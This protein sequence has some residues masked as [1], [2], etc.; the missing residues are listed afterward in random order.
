M[1][2]IPQ[3]ASHAIKMLAVFL[4]VFHLYTA[5]FGVFPGQIQRSVH[6]MIVSVMIFL[7]GI[8]T[9]ETA[10]KRKAFFNGIL[11]I[12]AV[13][14]GAYLILGYESIISRYGNFNTTDVVLGVIAVAI[15]LEATRRTMGWVL[16]LI[17]LAFIL[18]AFLGKWI[19]GLLGHNGVTA[20]RF[21]TFMY[22]T[23]DGIYGVALGV[24]ATFIFL[25]IL[26]GSFL[27]KTGA[28][29]FF[30]NLALAA[31][32][33]VTG[34][35][36]LASVASS[37]M[38]GSISG[39]G[40]ANVVTTGTFTIPLMK[41]TG[42]KPHFAGAVEAVAS[43]GG[44]LL[45]PVMGAAV[46]LMAELLGIPYIDIAIAATIPALLYFIA[47]AFA[48]YMEAKKEK[49]TL[50]NEKNLPRLK[51]TLREGFLYFLPLLIIIYLL[52]TGASP[53]KAAFYAIVSVVV[54]GL[55]KRNIPF[56]PKVILESMYDAASSALTVTA[57]T[58]CAGIIIGVVSLSGLGLKLSTLI[59]SLS[60]NNV[61]LALV[62][63]MI[64]SI[65]LGMGLPTSAAYLILAVLGG[66][67]LISM[68]VPDMAAHLFILYF[69]CLS[70]ITPPVALSAFAAAG[71]AG[72]PPMKTGFTS[73]RLAI[74]AFIIP[75]MF[76]YS[77]ALLMQGEWY[78]IA[79]ALLSALLGCFL[80]SS[81]IIGW[82]G[83]TLGMASRGVLFLT[84][85]LMLHPSL[86]TD[87]IG[88]AVLAVMLVI[89]K[90]I[91]KSESDVP[92]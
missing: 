72:S 42:Y 57:A 4:A 2:N 32:G 11:V 67:A 77:P 20:K 40:V 34:G 35:P 88:L 6:W 85:V 33:R 17:T 82:L 90:V 80:I 3:F 44:Q 60:N 63:T 48:V 36:A 21:F 43:N 5:F 76:I 38:M 7:L 68:G 62:I 22:L 8:S 66:P 49:V 50:L 16:P 25:F 53:M 70:T 30:V 31:T 78:S 61:F 19:P 81:S 1:T 56:N 71:I 45:P 28:G 23:T 52:F 47:V 89:N 9:S 92:A 24:S 54:I 14:T 64:V 29:T 41:K 10:V 84:S 51:E 75:Y 13:A 58:A 73:F 46:F 37:A 91:V 27:N 65:V 87:L 79:G 69:G 74:V 15:L 59:V 86:Y 83:R 39:S 26:F 12:L 55:V 18:Y